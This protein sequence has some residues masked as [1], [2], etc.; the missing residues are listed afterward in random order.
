MGVN[1]GQPV[2]VGFR[3]PGHSL[4][5][6]SEAGT[7]P[8][9]HGCTTT[10]HPAAPGLEPSGQAAG[11]PVAVAILLSGHFPAVA[12]HYPSWSGTVLPSGHLKVLKG[13]PS[14]GGVLP[15]GQSKLASAA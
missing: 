6:P 9:L 15:S 3:P 13:Q 10:E 14:L 8:S 12:G 2:E 11:Q 5:Q 7:D 1:E 4:G